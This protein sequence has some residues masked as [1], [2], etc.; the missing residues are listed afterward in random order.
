MPLRYLR[1][2]V[3][4]PRA[5][6]IAALLLLTT[7]LTVVPHANTHSAVVN[8]VSPPTRQLRSL[9]SAVSAHADPRVARTLLSPPPTTPI[10]SVLITVRQN[11]FEPSEIMRTAGRVFLIV[12]NRSGFQNVQ[13]RL[14]PSEGPRLYDVA[15]P[16]SMLDWVQVVD[17]QRGDYTLTDAYH[18]DWSCKIGVE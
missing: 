17:L 9:R 15:V 12:Q 6:L 3:K 10:G 14:D 7:V 11:G 2:A 1:S 18:P 16:R 5:I 8:A 13:L 4:S